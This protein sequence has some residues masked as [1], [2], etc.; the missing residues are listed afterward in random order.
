MAKGLPDGI[1]VL[2]VGCI[3]AGIAWCQYQATRAKIKLDLFDKRYA[4][5]ERAW[6]FMSEA[7]RA[8]ADQ[9]LPLFSE[10]DNVIPQAGFLFGEK[11]RKYLREVSQKRTD[12]SFIQ[13]RTQSNAN[14]MQPNDIER[15]TELMQWFYD[16]ATGGIKDVFGP[17]LNF[18]VW[19]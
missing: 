6:A 9:P 7:V 2:V 19:R 16:Q 3:A 12:L 13:Q 1:A 11:V 4:I 15:H 5:F 10:F 14:I 18:E 17:Y 8:R